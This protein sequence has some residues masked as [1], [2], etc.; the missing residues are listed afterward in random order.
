MMTSSYSTTPGLIRR[1]RTPLTLAAASSVLL[2]GCGVANSEP[3]TAAES[4][5][6]LR[7]ALAI[8]PT[9]LEPCDS[10]L[11]ST[12]MLVRSNVT[13]PLVERNPSTGDL[14]PLLATS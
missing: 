5:D 4:P 8:E 11:S 13:E 9:T 3:D 12:G 7:I 10:T 6:T 2:G 14:E 1:L